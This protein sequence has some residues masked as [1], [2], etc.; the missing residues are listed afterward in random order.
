[1]ETDKKVEGNCAPAHLRGMLDLAPFVENVEA[2]AWTEL[3]LALSP[4]VRARLG[5]D[6]QQCAGATLLLTRH[7]DVLQLNRVIGLG[8]TRAVT[9]TA[10]R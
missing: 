4:D 10:P 5:V 3:Q 2:R 6:V 9:A 1:M 8:I 7:A